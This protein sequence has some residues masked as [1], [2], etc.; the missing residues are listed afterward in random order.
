MANKTAPTVVTVDADGYAIIDPKAVKV[1]YDPTTPRPW[2]LHCVGC[3]K[4]IRR[5]DRAP[6]H[7]CFKCDVAAKTPKTAVAVKAAVPVAPAKTRKVSQN[8]RVLA[9]RM[10]MARARIIADRSQADA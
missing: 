9:N 8:P 5:A 10:V 1:A 3:E 7:S 2:K 6:G 4:P